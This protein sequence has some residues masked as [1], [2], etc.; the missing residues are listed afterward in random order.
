MQPSVS[1]HKTCADSI[2]CET[3]VVPHFPWLFSP[4]LPWRHAPRAIL[5]LSRRPP[6]RVVFALSLSR[7]R[8]RIQVALS[9]CRV[10]SLF[11][12]DAL[13]AHDNLF[14]TLVLAHT[15][16]FGRARSLAPFHALCPSLV[17]IPPA[18]A[19]DVGFAFPDASFP[20]KTPAHPATEG[21]MGVCALYAVL[22]RALT[23][24]CL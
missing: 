20:C 9:R 10:L 7:T 8:A 1:T 4:P 21:I 5:S 23:M 22:H 16:S 24:C 2:K 13:A 6:G 18:A 12:S 3:V 17:H 15:Q 11:R 19:D 14:R